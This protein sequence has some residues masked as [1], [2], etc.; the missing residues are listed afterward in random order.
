MP[1]P[2]GGLNSISAGSAMPPSDCVRL[3][4]LVPAEQGLRSRLGWREWCTGLTGSADNFVRSLHAFTGSAANGASNRVFAVTSTGIWDVTSSSTSPTQALAFPVTTGDAGYGYSTVMVAAG[5][6]YLLYCDEVNGYHVYS[7]SSG[8][9]T[10]IAFGAGPSEVGG[11]NPSNLVHVHV[12]KNRVWFVERDTG[13]AWYLATGAI[14]G[15]ATSLSMGRQFRAGGPLVGLYSWTY[16]GGSGMDDSLVGISNGGDVVIW[17]GTDP[18]SDFALRG[19]WQVGAPPAGRDLAASVG[20]DCW[21]LTRFGLQPISQLVVGANSEVASSQLPTAKVASLFNNAMQGKAA[22]KG[23][24]MRLHPED[25]T[26][27]VMVPTEDGQATEQLVM[28]LAP[29]SWSRYRDLPIYSSCVLSGKLYYGT[30][31]GKVGIND[32]YVDGRTLA[33][34]NSYTAVQWA[35]LTSFQ[36]LGSA[37][38]KQVQMV[39]PTFLTEGSA[40]S[41]N[42]QARYRYDFTELASVS[43]AANTG[44]LWDVG[45]W[46]SAVW[47]GDYQA[48]QNVTGTT[49]LG[50]DVAIAMRGTA[51]T[52]TVLVGIDVFFT[53]GGLL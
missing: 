46:D 52:R 6:H 45:T 34:P 22:K 21:L 26:L 14:Y 19:V 40:P 18:A 33:D 5:G 38:M 28:A 10:A 39:R 47:A 41:Y 1:V 9:W 20:G 42:A 4:N 51:I 30:V 11:V 50:G 25:A 15:T 23:W 17:Q 16:D 24:A 12:F 49:G 32:G 37:S 7:E 43:Q 31:D 27:L 48:T 13:N 8:T 36:N 53:V 2:M 35:L 3:F 44:S 29:R